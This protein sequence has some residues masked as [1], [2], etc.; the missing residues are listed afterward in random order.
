MLEKCYVEVVQNATL[1]IVGPIFDSFRASS[2]G[3]SS[4]SV[5]EA[6][7]SQK[8][9][10]ILSVTNQRNAKIISY[11]KSLH[12]ISSEEV[13]SSIVSAAREAEGVISNIFADD[14]EQNEDDF[15]NKL[16]NEINT[17][18]NLRKAL[19]AFDNHF[20][21]VNKEIFENATVF[22]VNGH[23]T[24]PISFNLQ[25]VSEITPVDFAQKGCCSIM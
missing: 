14:S 12:D 9:S 16:A 10:I 25:E 19:M 8:E 6:E 13:S 24:Q 21:M 20:I 2:D 23:K 1:S 17:N 22:D 7:I 4:N 3:H 18:N 15:A 11:V 5:Y